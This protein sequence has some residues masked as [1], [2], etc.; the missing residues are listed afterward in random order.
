MS[1]G[2]ALRSFGSAWTGP[3]S[4]DA[5]TEDLLAAGVEVPDLGSQ[6]ESVL[7]SFRALG[8]LHEVHS[9]RVT[10]I[11]ELDRFREVDVSR[12]DGAYGQ[13]VS[14]AGPDRRGGER[15]RLVRSQW[16]PHRCRGVPSRRRQG[17]ERA[18]RPDTLRAGQRPRGRGGRDGC[19]GSRR[20]SGGR[21]P[22]TPPGR[23]DMVPARRTEAASPRRRL[24]RRR[25]RVRGLEGSRA[26]SH[27]LPGA[28]PSRVRRL[29][30]SC[31]EPGLQPRE[32]PTYADGQPRSH[33][34]P[35]PAGRRDLAKRV[36][37]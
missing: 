2:V 4:V 22:T 7:Q 23:D 37:T 11:G 27:R 28:L 34:S 35:G 19:L 12:E 17:V 14:P 13:P 15:D 1:C 5:L 36:C 6:V 31:A 21:T 10:A 18:A 25:D 8:L 16:P 24:R 9:S 33:P 29:G 20:G 32:R 3:T 30:S 26:C